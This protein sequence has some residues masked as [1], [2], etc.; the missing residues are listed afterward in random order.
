MYHVD[1]I[2]HLL[3]LSSKVQA[4]IPPRQRISYQHA[5]CKKHTTI[6]YTLA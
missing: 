5:Q 2:S 1:Y 4:L 6:E 3:L